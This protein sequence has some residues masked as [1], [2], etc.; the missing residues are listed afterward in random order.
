MTAGSPELRSKSTPKMPSFYPQIL[1]QSHNYDGTIFS[2]NANRSF[3]PQTIFFENKILDYWNP[4]LEQD[5]YRF[6]IDT[7]KVVW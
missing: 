2:H 4:V 5:G 1:P 3:G 6:E 7:D